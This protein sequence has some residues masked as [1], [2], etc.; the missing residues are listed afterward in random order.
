MDTEALFKAVMVAALLAVAVFLW[1]NWQDKQ[2]SAQWPSVDGVIERC[3]A[4]PHLQDPHQEGA[5][6][7]WRLDLK[8]RYEVGG[9][10]FHGTRLKAMAE[11][12]P[13]EAS[14]KAVCRR[15]ATGQRVK[16]FHDPAKPERSV[17]EPG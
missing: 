3:D 17:L 15:Y 13:D 7:Q 2:A 11:H 12:Y 6:A 1:R 10:P 4:F 14:V 8:Y 5:K 9:Q 16:V